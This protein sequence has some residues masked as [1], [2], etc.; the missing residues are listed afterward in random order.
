MPRIL[1]VDAHEETASANKSALEGS[2][3]EVA[4]AGSV[5]EARVWINA[6][7]ADLIVA[8]LQ[9]QPDVWPSLRLEFRNALSPY[10]VPFIF[11]VGPAQGPVLAQML[12]DGNPVT[13]LGHPCDPAHLVRTVDSVLGA[14]ERQEGSFIG[15]SFLH[16]MAQIE[17]QRESGVL[18]AYRGH[19]VKKVVFREGIATFSGSNDPV[20]RVG[21]AFLRAGVGNETELRRAMQLTQAAG[22]SRLEEVFKE[23]A[24]LSQDTVLDVL[25]RRTR[26]TILSLYLWFD[27]K[28]EFSRA[29]RLSADKVYPVNVSLTDLRPR[30][31][32]RRRLWPKLKRTFVDEA[33]T[34]TVNWH[35][36]P[37]DFPG[38]DTDRRLLQ[39]AEQ[40]YTIGQIC[41]ELRGQDYVVFRKYVRW[42]DRGYL[43][44]NPSKP[45][46]QMPDPSAPAIT[47]IVD[48]L[49]RAQ[50]ELKRGNDLEAR[51]HYREAL[52]IDPANV[53]ARMGLQDAARYTSARLKGEGFA[54]DRE[55]SLSV[56]L[57]ELTDR[58][59]PAADS[60]VLSRLAAGPLPIQDLVNICP[61]D[62]EDVLLILQHWYAQQV[63][64]FA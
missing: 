20:D 29:E 21:Q 30:G 28:W 22:T 45:A 58:Q 40:G 49:Q 37:K 63:V 8:D 17:R 31:E 57:E 5:D 16:I 18:T 35:R 19:I 11:I 36:F 53:N 43:T 15:D 55:V 6:T 2:G 51:Q 48:I 34:F 26:D 59:L 33:M 41:L 24:K 39:V 54:P 23:I 42:A 62:E 38:S 32:E 7:G 46:P 14:I 1:I 9:L 47:G 25:T 13:A 50:A 12:T 56:A 60:F 27:G 3:H 10:V 52:D 44:F 61:I 64:V 4:V